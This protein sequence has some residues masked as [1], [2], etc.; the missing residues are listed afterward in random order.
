[1]IE[2]ECHFGELKS[3]IGY[4]LISRPPVDVTCLGPPRAS[5]ARD[6]E[7]LP[8]SGVMKHSRARWYP[9]GAAGDSL[10]LA[11]QSR[12]TKLFLDARVVLVEAV[13]GKIPLPSSSDL[14]SDV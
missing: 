13:K 5:T 2:C 8:S 10:I 4:S 1:V 7:G 12:P 11:D 3:T 6:H 14:S 9:P